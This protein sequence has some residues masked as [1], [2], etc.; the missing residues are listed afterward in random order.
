M[1]IRDSLCTGKT[2]VQFAGIPPFA[3]EHFARVSQVDTMTVSYTHL[4]GQ[5]MG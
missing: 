3:P 1:C 5:F 2:H 4:M